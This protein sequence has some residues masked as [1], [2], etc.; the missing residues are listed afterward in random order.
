MTPEY[1]AE[2]DLIL[3]DVVRLEHVLD[4]DAVGKVCRSFFA[5]FGLPVRVI[6][7]DGELL[8]DVHQDRPLCRYLNSFGSGERACDNTVGDVRNVAPA[9]DSVVHPCFSGAAYHVTPIEYQG[10]AVGRFVI[11]PYVPAEADE[12][13]ASLLAVD[14]SLDARTALSHFEAMPRVARDVAAKLAAHLRGTLEILVFS[15]HRT[16]L[17]S[18]MQVANVRENYRELAEKNERLRASFEELQELDKLKSSFLATVSH[19]LRTP[20]TSIIGYTEMLESGAAGT[21]S[22]GQSEFLGTIRHKADQLL[23]LIGRLLD[24]G[25][26][27]A[28]T[29]KLHKEAVDAR[30]LLS[31]V[32][33]T[34]VPAA[35]RR[36]IVL[37]I[38]IHDDT[39]KLF[40]DPV[41]LRQI[42]LNLAENAVKFTPEGGNIALLAAPGTI[43]TGVGGG[44]GEALF[45]S[46]RTAVVLTVRDSG[47]GI[48]EEQVSRIFNAFYQIDGGTTREHGGAGLGLSI[49]KQ[50]VDAHDGRIEVTSVVGEGTVFVITLPAAED[51]G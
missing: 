30:G 14:P 5:L 11:G 33:S 3:G 51:H 46:S 1:P 37:D 21:L 19:E 22:D 35:N 28:D 13:P 49:A 31:D 12:A 7:H 42:V 23:G 39:P 10:R 44:L 40:G 32:G 27:E 26:L 45:S 38:D 41:R 47:R 17:A 25:R 8:A 36:N 15:G 29:M 34:I 16:Q 4:R 9:R 24:L 50:L 20:L 6:A 18:T 2:G 48:P 43:D